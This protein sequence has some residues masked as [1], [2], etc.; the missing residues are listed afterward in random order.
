MTQDEAKVLANL[1]G[2]RTGVSVEGIGR[3]LGWHHIGRDTVHSPSRCR[4]Q[5]SRVL[6]ALDQ[7]SRIGL[8]QRKQGARSALWYITANDVTVCAPHG[9]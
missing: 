6:K 4:V 9:A 1:Q 3:S 2:R 5:S 8:V 7:L